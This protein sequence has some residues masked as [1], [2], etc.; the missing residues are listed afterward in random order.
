VG[1]KKITMRK[2]NV[3][4]RSLS[5]LAPLSPLSA[6]LRMS[7]ATRMQ[8]VLRGHLSLARICNS[9]TVISN[10]LVGV[11]LAGK[12]WPDLRVGLVMLAMLCFYCAGMYLNG[13]MD[14][15]SDCRERPERPLPSGLIT[16]ASAMNVMLLLFGAG[17]FLLLLS[18]GIPFLCGVLLS[19][20]M[21][22]YNRWHK[23][24]SLS[25][26]L[27][28]LCR[29]MIYLSTFLACATQYQTRDLWQVLVASTLLVCYV[30]S[31]TAIAKTERRITVPTSIV[32]IT[33]FMP[34]LYII[35]RLSWSTLWL[36][37]LAAG[38]VG[39][40][41]YSIS[42]VYRR[43]RR[44]VGRAVEQLIAGISLVDALILA[45]S[46]SMVGG[47]IALLA[48]GLTLCLQRYVRGA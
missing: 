42:L 20:L 14:Y 5:P 28:G 19:I 46:G 11:V 48:F 38:F 1:A 16:R 35:T 8:R 12:F 43:P 4:Y 24:H 29:G 10:V 34:L 39:W 36:L 7:R 3:R 17:S 40:N 41:W 32:I 26:L 2:K 44:L 47:A 6:S 13:L 37:P 33:L 22:C 18:G 21:V 31:L 25:P 9:P 27:M 45:V 15:A 30:T 23:Q